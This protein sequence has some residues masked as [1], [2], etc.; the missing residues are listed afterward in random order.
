MIGGYIVEKVSEN[1][2]RVT[3]MS[4]GDI[5]GSIP[6]FVKRIFSQNQGSVA[7]RVNGLLKEWREKKLKSKTWFWWIHTNLCYI[8]A[9]VAKS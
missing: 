9:L 6:D 7:S 3:Y 2:C 8:F 1:K 5:K 4:D